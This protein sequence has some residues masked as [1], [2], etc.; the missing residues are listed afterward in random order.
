MP[1]IVPP[2]SSQPAEPDLATHKPTSP[3]FDI[4][5]RRYP[6]TA[7]HQLTRMGYEVAAP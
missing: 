2:Q 1:R 7:A 3:R 6:E 4:A 5:V